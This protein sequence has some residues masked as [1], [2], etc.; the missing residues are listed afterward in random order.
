MPIRR[1]VGCGRRAPQP[2]LRR[3][4]ARGNALALASR[5]AAGRGAYTC[6]RLSCFERALAHN[7]FPRALRTRLRIDP[8]LFRVYTDERHG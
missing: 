2:E 4:V 3:F 5:T 6:D 1:C 7:A 8:D